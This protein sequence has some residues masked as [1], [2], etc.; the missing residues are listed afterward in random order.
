MRIRPWL[1][2][3]CLG[4]HALG[5]EFEDEPAAHALYDGMVAAMQK[6]QTLTYACEQRREYGTWKSDTSRYRVWLRKPNH[7]R[8]ETTRPGGRRGGTLIGDGEN[9][10]VH[11]PGRRPEFSTEDHAAW[12][13]TSR[14]V[15]MQ[16]RTPPG[17]HSIAHKMS[18]LGAG[19]GMAII[20]PSLFHG[21][22]S[23]LDPYLD[24]VR[25]LGTKKVGGEECDGI[26]I[27]YMKHQRSKYVWLSRKDHL[28][29]E[30]KEV[31]R[32]SRHLANYER[33]TD[34]EIDAEVEDDLFRW[35]PP[36]GWKKWR[37]P[38][39]S[40]QLLERGTAAPDFRQTL[41]NGEPLSLS[42]LKGK[43]VWLVFWRV[44]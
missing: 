44:G 7:F 36:A 38:R 27:S 2:V 34:I 8:I 3:A 43:I 20:N 15:Y 31:V 17:M 23:S 11:W 21:A 29:R 40:E 42:D 35:T 12:L 24:G 37:L 10:W 6:A 4:A 9:L 1:L 14:K 26:E 13:A 22:G 32:V 18:V 28:P 5:Q 30:L 25:S 39:Q 16:E 19:L 33:W 41:R